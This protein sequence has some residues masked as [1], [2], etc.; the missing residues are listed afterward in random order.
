MPQTILVTGGT[1]F[2]GRRVCRALLEREIPIVILDAQPGDEVLAT[3]QEERQ[4]K[5]LP[6]D[7]IA[8][9]EADV[10]DLEQVEGVFRQYPAISRVIHMAYLM[11]AAVEE[12]PALGAKV[13][14]VGTA[15]TLDVSVRHN[16]ERV[17]LTSSEAVYGR[18][19]KYY[20]DRAVTEDDFCGPTDHYF[21]YGAMKL[22]NEFMGRKYAAKHNLSVA[23]LRPSIVF[24]FGRG[25]GAQQWAEAFLSNPAIGQSAALPFPADNRDNWIYVD[26]CAEQLIRLALKPELEHYVYNSGG[27]TVS[28]AQLIGKI[29]EHL[30]QAEVSFDDAGEY[31]PLID[32]MD[33]SRLAKEIEFEP[34]S[35]SD[36]I[37]GHINDARTA[38][39]MAPLE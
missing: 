18:S 39:G 9:A 25:K 1:G 23:C 17:V 35:L 22:L 30:P 4:R 2:I 8:I 5:H 28:V 37:L 31:T 14:I 29:R 12:D 32:D 34:R 13:N 27:E 15:N 33:G 16:I 24:G 21:T 3:L 6:E 7:H 19:Q 38:A 20:G 10:T 26:D 11:T 36:G